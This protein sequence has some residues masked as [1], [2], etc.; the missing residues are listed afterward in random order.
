[1]RAHCALSACIR[2]PFC[3]C[4]GIHLILCLLL[5]STIHVGNPESSGTLCRVDAN[6]VALAADASDSG[7]GWRAPCT[8]TPLVATGS[9]V[10]TDKLPLACGSALSPV[11]D[12]DCGDIETAGKVCAP[13]PGALCSSAP[14][15][16][17]IGCSPAHNHSLLLRWICP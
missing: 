9:V 3:H 12:A 16:H 15:A 13:Q 10:T 5:F 6:T 14:S 17:F 1:M 8:P 4:L 11:S 2:F 7:Y